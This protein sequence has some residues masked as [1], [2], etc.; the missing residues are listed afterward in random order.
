ML[1]PP[2]PPPP[3]LLDADDETATCAYDAPWSNLSQQQRQA[4]ELLGMTPED[5]VEETPAESTLSLSPTTPMSA[6][7]EPQADSAFSITCTRS[8][9]ATNKKKRF[10][11]YVLQVTHGG[12]VF[13]VKKRWAQL[14]D[15]L[16][17]GLGR[18]KWKQRAHRWDDHHPKATLA[19]KLFS[20]NDN[21]E[22]IQRRIDEINRFLK[23]VSQ[24]E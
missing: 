13:E 20:S 18:I 10:T 12:R 24:L 19:K 11:V 14:Y 16:G 8:E 21:Q 3:L 5:F 6:K 1:A 22:E 4:A 7:P 2:P 9:I 23:S 17:S 15:D